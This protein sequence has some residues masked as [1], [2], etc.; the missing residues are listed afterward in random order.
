MKNENE[1]L[2]EFITQQGLDDSLFHLSN[3]K[4]FYKVKIATLYLNKNSRNKKDFIFEYIQK[5]YYYLFITISDNLNF[6]KN[7]DKIPSISSSIHSIGSFAQSKNN[8]HHL[9]F[10]YNKYLINLNICAKN[11]ESEFEIVHTVPLNRE[12]TSIAHST[13]ESISYYNDVKNIL[14]RDKSIQI[15]SFIQYLDDYFIIE[16]EN[17]K[18]E[19]EILMQEDG[20][21]NVN[22]IL[23]KCKQE[24]ID[25]YT[26][27]KYSLYYSK[28]SLTNYLSK[29]IYDIIHNFT[30]LPNDLLMKFLENFGILL[31][32]DNNQKIL[33]PLK[34]KI[35]TLRNIYFNNKLNH[36]NK[37]ITKLK[38]SKHFTSVPFH[39]FIKLFC[40]YDLYYLD[41][42]F[43]VKQSDLKKKKYLFLN[44][45]IIIDEKCDRIS[46]GHKIDCRLTLIDF[47]NIINQNFVQYTNSTS[48]T[49]DKFFLNNLNKYISQYTTYKGFMNIDIILNEDSMIDLKCCK[50]K[51][52]CN[53]I[54]NKIVFKLLSNCLDLCN[55][56]FN[57]NEGF[58]HKHFS[59]L[60][61][62][63]NFNEKNIIHTFANVFDSSKKNKIRIFDIPF[64]ESWNCNIANL[65]LL[66]W[67]EQYG[68]GIYDKAE[69]DNITNEKYLDNSC[70]K[71]LD[72]YSTTINTIAKDFFDKYE[73]ALP[74]FFH[75]CYKISKFPLNKYN[76]IDN[77]CQHFTNS[78]LQLLLK[79]HIMFF[80][81]YEVIYDINKENARDNELFNYPNLNTVL[82]PYLINIDDELKNYLKTK[83]KQDKYLE[84][85]GLSLKDYI[86]TLKSINSEK[87]NYNLILG[88]IIEKSNNK[89]S[90]PRRKLNL[91][92]N[93]E[94]ILD[95]EQEELI[96]VESE[97]FYYE[98]SK[99]SYN[100]SFNLN[101]S[102]FF[103]YKLSNEIKDKVIDY[104]ILK[105][106][107]DSLENSQMLSFDG[108]D[109]SVI[110]NAPKNKIYFKNLCK[111]TKKAIM[112]NLKNLHKISSY[113]QNMS[114]IFNNYINHV[115][116]KIKSKK[117]IDSS[118]NA[119]IKIGHFLI[120]LNSIETGNAVDKFLTSEYYSNFI[121]L[122]C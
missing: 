9:V 58:F 89:L 101:L 15:E 60:D 12:C 63:Y 11:E 113:S 4:K 66:I 115:V 52:K 46:R 33:F 28:Q 10:D 110:K 86:S 55:S 76:C 45:S 53:N 104:A 30:N 51:K 122:N 85:I 107:I 37:N 21:L 41:K 118:K 102:H 99:L 93:N 67:K 48:E 23:T 90:S 29:Y 78:S 92:E 40:K 13:K 27:I 80:H 14:T 108:Y 17:K 62:S 106:Y 20:V 65:I 24:L 39:K 35:K 6:C 79:N 87:I 50:S 81:P 96:Y 73:E 114:Y 19:N 84:Q 68:L 100:F 69:R 25:L 91:I 44:N 43:K 119:Y 103:T 83:D 70:K 49:I 32:K 36:L 16:I 57:F 42:E 22:F 74:N 56:L 109:G 18:P 64:S 95:N 121:H 34:R 98:P 7:T 111:D 105:R 75:F 8:T 54:I 71:L 3:F 94:N 117:N 72:F 1:E 2:S 77:I 5:K 112:L 26:M 82:E 97:T 120:N 61:Y 47:F 88:R 31:T 38:K 59:I 116:N